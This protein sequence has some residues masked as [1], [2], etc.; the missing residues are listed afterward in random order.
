MVLLKSNQSNKLDLWEELKITSLTR[1]LAAVYGCCILSVMLRVQLNLM[2]GYL[3]LDS[4]KQPTNGH[5]PGEEASIPQKVQ[6]RY[7]AL[8]KRFVEQGL[9]DFI[10]Y[11]RL[12]VTKE[13]GPIPLKEPLRLGQMEAVLGAVRERVECGV[14]TPTQAL[15]PYLL[16]SETVPDVTNTVSDLYS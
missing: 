10:N 8:V 12:A 13:I 4:L 3:C 1:A 9:P 7:L 11:L 5:L 2:G 14:D 6:G 15:T 16:A